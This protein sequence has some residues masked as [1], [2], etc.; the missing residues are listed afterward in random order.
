[1]RCRYEDVHRSWVGERRR[2]ALVW[3]RGRPVAASRAGKPVGPS[4]FPSRSS[5]PRDRSPFSPCLLLRR[6]PPLPR[7]HQIHRPR[8]PRTDRTPRVGIC[9][10]AEWEHAII[11]SYTAWRRLRTPTA[12]ASTSTSTS[13]PHRTQVVSPFGTHPRLLTSTWTSS[14][15]RWRSEQR[16]TW[17][18]ADSWRRA[19]SGC[20]ARGLA[21]AAVQSCW[22]LSQRG[23]KRRQSGKTTVIAAGVCR[24]PRTCGQ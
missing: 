3:N 9:R 14:L 5:I 21:G 6:Q 15:C 10:A 16:M 7:R 2:A 8:T 20:P 18:A 19:A 22:L 12:A 13:A 23:V 1:V 17:P 24:L 11:T 4:V